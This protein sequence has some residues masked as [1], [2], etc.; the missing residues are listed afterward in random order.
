MVWLFNEVVKGAR[1][2]SKFLYFLF[3]LLLASSKSKHLQNI[4]DHVN[5]LLSIFQISFLLFVFDFSFLQHFRVKI[6]LFVFLL[7]FTVFF[8]IYNFNFN[9]RRRLIFF[10]FTEFIFAWVPEVWN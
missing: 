7:I 1:T 9:L 5:N 8:F 3:D 10:F 2:F 4:N 6:F